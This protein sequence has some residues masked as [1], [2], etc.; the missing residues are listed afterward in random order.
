MPEPEQLEPAHHRGERLGQ[1]GDGAGLA[2]H[3]AVA[4]GDVDAQPLGLVKREQRG[5][6]HVARRLTV[7]GCGGQRRRARPR[8][9]RVEPS[10]LLA[11]L[12]GERGVRHKGAEGAMGGKDEHRRHDQAGHDG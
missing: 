6:E 10:P 9:G 8:P 3:V 2:Q 11:V 1:V 7:I 5:Q 12:V 4:R